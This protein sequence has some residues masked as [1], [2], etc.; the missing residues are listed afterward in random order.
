[1]YDR[2]GFVNALFAPF[3]RKKSLGGRPFGK[4]GVKGAFLAF[5]STLDSGLPKPTIGQGTNLRFFLRFVP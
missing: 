3:G 5:I 1:M 2:V 4:D